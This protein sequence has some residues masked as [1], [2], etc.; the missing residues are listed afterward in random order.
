MRQLQLFWP[1]WVIATILAL[2]CSVA[3]HEGFHAVTLRFFG[4][5]FRDMSLGWCGL[6]PCVLYPEV[7]GT[8]ETVNLFVGGLGSAMAF[9]FF[10]LL[11]RHWTRLSNWHPSVGLILAFMI[12]FQTS[13]GLMEALDNDWYRDVTTVKSRGLLQLFAGFLG[14]VFHIGMTGTGIWRTKLSWLLAKRR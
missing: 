14:I 3:I 4:V 5:A 7:P 1:I 2:L 9:S 8:R 11:S 13:T 12:L 6:G 10:Y